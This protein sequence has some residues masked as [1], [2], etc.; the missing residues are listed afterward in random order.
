MA[1]MRDAMYSIKIR[2][3][4]EKIG[5]LEDRPIKLFTIKKYGLK[6]VSVSYRKTR[7]SLTCII[8]ELS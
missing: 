5:K 7:S 8:L 6:K 3:D 4:K 1:K 2:V